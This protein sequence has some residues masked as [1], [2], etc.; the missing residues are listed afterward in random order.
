MPMRFKTLIPVILGLAG[1]TTGLTAQTMTDGNAAI[2]SGSITGT[3]RAD[4]AEWVVT[5]PEGDDLPTSYVARD[6]GGYTVQVVGYPTGAAMDET[7]ALVL[8]FG[9]TGAPR[10]WRADN[11][12]LAYATVDAPQPFAAGEENIDLQITA[13]EPSGSSAALA[14]DVVAS[15]VPGGAGELVI[16]PEVERL[17]DGNFQVT[18]P[19]R[20]AED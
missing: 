5:A 10:D 15:L 14:G 12:T 1:V 13:F 9:L 16:D 4:A 17:I 11:A 18:L 7:G 3:V 20:D 2:P 19:L 8:R 6:E